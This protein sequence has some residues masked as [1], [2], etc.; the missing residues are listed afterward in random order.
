MNR[1]CRHRKHTI[2][3]HIVTYSLTPPQK[4]NTTKKYPKQIDASAV[5]I[6]ALIKKIPEG[7][8]QKT[9]D[10]HNPSLVTL[11]PEEFFLNLS[12]YLENIK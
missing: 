6:K 3:T 5:N 1:N 11:S 9:V 4:K 7:L 10:V 2:V 12:F 8:Y